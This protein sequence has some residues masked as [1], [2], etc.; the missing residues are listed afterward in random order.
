MYVYSVQKLCVLFLW[1]LTNSRLSPFRKPMTKCTNACLYWINCKNLWQFSR[2]R[3]NYANRIS[4]AS[5]SSSSFS[6][7]SFFFF[8]RGFFLFFFFFPFPIFSSSSS[9]PS[10]S[11]FHRSLFLSCSLVCH[12]MALDGLTVPNPH[13]SNLYV[14]CLTN[15]EFCR[16]L[17]IREAHFTLERV[18]LGIAPIGRFAAQAKWHAFS[19]QRK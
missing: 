14:S 6:S 15:T 9:F 11:T 13:S 10:S 12:W 4:R 19:G 5:F 1:S 2:W 8:F 16:S 7:S 17:A 3:T 18:Q